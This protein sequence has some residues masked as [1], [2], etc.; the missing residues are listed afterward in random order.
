MS[1]S[2]LGRLRQQT[3]FLQRQFLQEGELP[4]TGV[5]FEKTIA[6]ALKPRDVV[7]PDR[8]CSPLVTRWF[9]LSQ[10]LSNRKHTWEQSFR[11]TLPPASSIWRCP[12]SRAKGCHA[13]NQTGSELCRQDG[14]LV[15]RCWP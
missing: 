4:F 10:V 15:T 6:Q 1:V 5:L 9:C 11:A 12:G 2:H 3:R 13:L 8:I 14:S 7:W